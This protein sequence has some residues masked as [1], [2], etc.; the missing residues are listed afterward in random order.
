M[1]KDGTNGEILL[2]DPVGQLARELLKND[3]LC[4]GCYRYDGTDLTRAEQLADEF[5]LPKNFVMRLAL[6]VLL[7]DH[8]QHGERSVITQVSRRV[9]TGTT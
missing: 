1:T 5:H 6:K 7:I 2:F 4:Q 3:R 9:K 8:A